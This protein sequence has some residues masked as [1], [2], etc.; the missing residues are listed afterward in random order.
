MRYAGRLKALEERVSDMLKYRNNNRPDI[1][2]GVLIF[3]YL[4]KQRQFKSRHQA[5][6]DLQGIFWRKFIDQ[7]LAR[8]ESQPYLHEIK[9]T[10]F[11]EDGDIA[12][13]DYENAR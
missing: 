11:L 1:E 3:E 10:L 13:L 4:F 8:A 6:N 5:F 7:M 9:D 12:L 2:E